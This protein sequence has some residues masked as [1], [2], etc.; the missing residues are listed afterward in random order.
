MWDYFIV[1]NN[2]VAKCKLCNGEYSGKGRGTYLGNH[3]I[4]KHKSQYGEM[5]INDTVK[6]T[7]KKEQSKSVK[8]PLGQMKRDIKQRKVDECFEYV[9]ILDASRS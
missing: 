4:S 8:T 7:E 5:V 2:D 6:A 9:K 3:L 1:K